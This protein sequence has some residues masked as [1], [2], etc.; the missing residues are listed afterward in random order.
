MLDHLTVELDDRFN[1]ES[2]LIVREFMAILPAANI[3]PNTH[4]N[5]NIRDLYANDLYTI[6]LQPRLR[7]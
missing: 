1:P 2:T 3:F 7:A 5:S 4:G 6:S